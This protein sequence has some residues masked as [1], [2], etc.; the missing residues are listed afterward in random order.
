M[1]ALFCTTQIPCGYTDQLFMIVH[2]T[3][4]HSTVRYHI[5]II[6]IMKRLHSGQTSH[7]CAFPAKTA[8]F[9]NLSL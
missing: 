4:V 9:Q 1:V 6:V 8:R 2:G 5:L 3:Q 7:A